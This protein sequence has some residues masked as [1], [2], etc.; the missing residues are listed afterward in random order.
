[1]VAVRSGSGVACKVSDTLS[2]GHT[3]HH[4]A[5]TLLIL[6]TY[7]VK[8]IGVMEMVHSVD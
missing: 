5:N 1:M 4:V 8:L 3:T 7:Q 6:Q 2:I